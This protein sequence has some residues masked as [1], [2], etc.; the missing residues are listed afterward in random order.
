M[1]TKL[2]MIAVLAG[3]LKRQPDLRIKYGRF[4]EVLASSFELVDV[5]D[6]SL[7]GMQRWMNAARTFDIQRKT[8]KERIY[9]NV[10]AFDLRT[11]RAANYLRTRKGQYDVV[12]QLGASFDAG[13]SLTPTVLYTDYT[14]ALSVFLCQ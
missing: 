14:S 1:S 6:T 10:T 4:F 7:K 13:A 11:Q 2:R 12:L 3:D 9:K 5:F 8:W